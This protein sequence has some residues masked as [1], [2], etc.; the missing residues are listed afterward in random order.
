MNG[1]IAPHE[2]TV[3]AL[4]FPRRLAGLDEVGWDLLVRQAHKAD[5]LP[6]LH[7]HLSSCGVLDLAPRRAR[8]HFEAAYRVAEKHVQAVRWEI[9]QVR[10]AVEGSG[11]PLV[12]LKGAAYLAAGLPPAAGRVFA[13][14]D[15]MVPHAALG[16]VEK[17][18]L[19]HGWAQEKLHPYDQRY[20][21]RWMH[22]L[23]PMMH[24]RRGTLLDV[25][26]S[27]L[28]LTSRYPLD[29]RPLY[30]ASVAVGVDPGLRVLAPADMV[31]HSATHL[32]CDGE[33]DHALR[34][35]ADLDDLLRHFGADEAF[36]PHLAARAQALGLARPLYYAVEQGRR[37]LGMQVPAVL[38]EALRAAAP[39]AVTR[40]LM[41]ALLERAMPPEHASCDRP[42]SGVARELLYV[43][44]H[45][46]RMPLH[47]LAPHLLRK[48]WRREEDGD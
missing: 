11:V 7:V 32:F 1:A 2:L 45:Y 31:L 8:L 37:L 16:Q 27:I 3:T 12:L 25:H 42:F 14:V 24:R 33:F 35:L 6:R 43:R 19:M 40:R 5:L 41:G 36:W 13:D 10:A 39:G 18:L 46:L 21:R 29:P 30:R 38:D 44:G 4:R 26:H 15:V 20:Y 23:P 47:L 34:D 22:E 17:C 28:P 48:S 9:R